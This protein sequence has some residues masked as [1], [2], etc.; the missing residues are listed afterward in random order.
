M[1]TTLC[2][3]TSGA[4]C[5][6]A[7]AAD[8]RVTE[9]DQRLERTHNLHLLPMLDDL[10]RS[11]GLRIADLDLVAFGC[12]PGSFTGVRIAAAVCQAVA[13]AADAAVVAIGSS[14]ALAQSAMNEHPTLERCVT[15]IASRGNAYYMAGFARGSRD[16]PGV[17]VVHHADRLVDGAPPW[18]ADFARDTRFAMVG[19]RPEWLSGPF[20]DGAHARA[21]DMLVIARSMHRAGKSGP[22]E[23]A[24]PTYIAGDSPWRKQTPSTSE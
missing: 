5:S 15:C 9:S 8:D 20:L 11:A 24:L 23:R 16:E 22:P 14:H 18:L 12:G 6:L 3:E 17:P 10:L 2:I 13:L 1:T 21:R 7:I 4:N 19:T